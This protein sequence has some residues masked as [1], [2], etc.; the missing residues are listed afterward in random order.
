MREPRFIEVEASGELGGVGVG[1]E[2]LVDE[3]DQQRRVTRDWRRP[4]RPSGIEGRSG[5]RYDPCG[6]GWGVGGGHGSCGHRPSGSQRA[7]EA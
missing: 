2:Q 6:G 5:G 4:Q 7:Q 3:L 1:V